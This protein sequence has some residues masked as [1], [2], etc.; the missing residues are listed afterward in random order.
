MT[1][2]SNL[3]DGRGAGTSLTLVAFVVGVFLL[4]AAPSRA[5]EEEPFKLPAEYTSERYELLDTWQEVLGIAPETTTVAKYKL[6]D[7]QEDASLVVVVDAAG[8]VLSPLPE[9]FPVDLPFF[10]RPWPDGPGGEEFIVVPAASSKLHPRLVARFQ[11]EEAQPEIAVLSD[12][13]EIVHVWLV[14]PEEVPPDL[15]LDTL[16]DSVDT[17][18]DDLAPYATTGE[19]AGAI[20]LAE[21]EA[22]EAR[23]VV[24]NHFEAIVQDF[25]QQESIPEEK[26]VYRYQYAPAVTLRLTLAECLG[27]EE[28]EHVNFLFPDDELEKELDQVVLGAK[29]T[30]VWSQG[31]DGSGATIGHIER[32][33]GRIATSAYLSATAYRPFGA[34]DSHATAI[35][36]IIRSTHG[37]YKGVA[38]GCTLLSAN[39]AS[40][41]WSDIAAATEWAIGKGASILNMSMGY[42]EDPDARDALHWSDIYFD[43]V[44][45]YSRVLFTKS[46]GNHRSDPDNG[47]RV[48]SPGRGYNSLTV[49]NIDGKRTARWND[50]V[51]RSSSC[52][53]NPATGGDKPEIAAYGTDVRST[54]T[55]SP[56]VGDVGSGTSF[57]APVVAGIAGLIIDRYPGFAS[58][59]QLV[60]AMILASGLSHNIEGDS[61]VSDKDGVG[62]ALA[63]AINVGGAGRTLNT[64]KFDSSGFYELNREISLSRNNPVRVVL[65]YTYPPSSKTALPDSSSYDKSDLDLY[66][67][68]GG[69][70]VASSRRGTRNAFE[71]IDYTPSTSGT[72]HVK[73]KKYKWHS[74]VSSIRAGIAWASRSRLGTRED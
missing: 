19:M 68:V 30:G 61:E 1:A 42:V 3:S 11:E 5:Q 24:G 74:D 10:L 72:A 54:T 67:Y 31:Y 65:V 15:P 45:H 2:Q 50:D 35:G 52:Y 9:E 58:W 59:P 7:T 18:E 6:H 17:D 27:L 73:I 39:A 47:W 22:I 16:E 53:V 62:A 55:S 69:T 13:E 46:A 56:W 33:P 26:I 57:A 28:S 70:R 43:Y 34:T 44:V 48:T 4:P 66:L 40:S 63:T 21:Q 49:G 14:E 51:M 12:R 60:K 71:V 20:W 64:D 23:A 36:G 37:S 38:R 8:N 29:V 25:V 41:S 32:E